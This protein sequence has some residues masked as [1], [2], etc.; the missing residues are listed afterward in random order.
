MVAHWIVDISDVQA[1]FSCLDGKAFKQMLAEYANSAWGGGGGLTRDQGI[2]LN[3]LFMKSE[4]LTLTLL[5]L[6]FIHDKVVTRLESS[7]FLIVWSDSHWLQFHNIYHGRNIV[8]F[9]RITI[10]GNRPHLSWKQANF[11]FACFGLEAQ[12]YSK[13]G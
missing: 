11:K 3:R 10:C 1:L 9:V 4:A 7:R 13:E 6:H 12:T 2:S 8:I 5:V